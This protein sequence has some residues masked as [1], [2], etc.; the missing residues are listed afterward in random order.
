MRSRV[1]YSY[2]YLPLRSLNSGWHGNCFYI[3]DDA[4]TTLLPFSVTPPVRSASWG[5]VS[6][7]WCQA[8]VMEI[9]E[10]LKGR[11]LAGLDGVAVLWVMVKHRILP[12]KR[13]AHLLCDYFRA[14]DPTREATEE[15]EDDVIMQQMAGLASGGV[16]VST[17]CT[18]MEFSTSRRPNLVSH[19][20]LCFS[21]CPW[22]ASGV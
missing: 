9:L 8:K 12:L 3:Y 1:S 19:P 21:L 4:S 16:M 7:W 20:F 5:R 2:P 15:L 18:V 6:H 14:K 17:K 22:S 11:V 10:I 13:R